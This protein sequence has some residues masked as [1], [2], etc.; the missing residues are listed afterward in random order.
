MELNLRELPHLVVGSLMEVHKELGPG[1]LLEAYWT[2]LAHEF[3]MREILFKERHPVA[4]N[5]KGLN[6]KM[7]FTIDFVV[8]D[9]MALH[10][11]AVDELEQIHKERLK[12][13][14]QLSGLEMGFMVNFDCVDFRK[15]GLKRVIV[16]ENEPEMPWRGVDDGEDKVRR[17]QDW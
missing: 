17:V 6:I 14:L 5:Y 10:L 1:L 11:Y 4:V 15:G 2:S 8:E 13:H 12:S 3:R 9:V 16:S 7:G